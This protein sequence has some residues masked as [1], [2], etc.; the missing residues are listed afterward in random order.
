M[1]DRNRAPIDDAR[2]C[3]VQCSYQDRNPAY[4]TYSCRVDPENPHRLYD[5]PCSGFRSCPRFQDAMAVQVSTVLLP[6][7]S[8]QGLFRVLT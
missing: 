2:A 4:Q 7:V 3:D 8:F 5:K 1:S 6:R